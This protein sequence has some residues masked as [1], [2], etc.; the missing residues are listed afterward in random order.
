MYRFVLR[1]IP[2]IQHFRKTSEVA[3]SLI[4]YATE[5]PLTVSSAVRYL[6]TRV[7]SVAEFDNRGTHDVLNTAI[8]KDVAENSQYIGERPRNPDLDSQHFSTIMAS[9]LKATK[10][11]YNW[12]S[13]YVSWAELWCAEHSMDITAMIQGIRGASSET[14][15]YPLIEPV[16]NEALRAFQRD[17]GGQLLRIVVT[18]K[19]KV[20]GGPSTRL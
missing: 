7:E 5:V 11:D 3:V 16:L 1:S 19:V 13:R 4:Y 17:H 14:A 8:R 15:S 9:V 18:D 2:F 20:Q 10:P 12:S 6:G